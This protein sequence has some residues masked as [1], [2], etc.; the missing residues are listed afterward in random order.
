[1]TAP[2]RA[3]RP[4][5]RASRGALALLVA[6]IAL[7]VAGA[8]AQKPPRPRAGI[9]P[10]DLA[11]VARATGDDLR[12]AD[13]DIALAGKRVRFLARVASLED[14][15]DGRSAGTFAAG[16]ARLVLRFPAPLDAAGRLDHAT[17]W[18]VI[19][20]LLGPVALPD[21]RAAIAV[22]ADALVKTPGLPS[23]ERP[24][25]VVARV[26]GR[27]TFSD[28]RLPDGES[29]QPLYR[30]R[31][32]V[33]GHSR[34]FTKPG[35]TAL[36]ATSDG[37]GRFLE[38]RANLLADDGRMLAVECR[39]RI[40]DGALRNFEVSSAEISPAGEQSNPSSVD[41]EDDRWHDKWSARQKPFPPNTYAAN[42]LLPAMSGFPVGDA[43]VVR[44]HVWGDNSIPVPLYAYLDGEETV[45]VRGR[46]EAA[47]RVR[48]GLDA[49]EAARTIDLP[50]TFR[51][52]AEGASEVWFA[53]ESTWWIARD[54][55]H[56]VLRYRGPLGAPGSPEVETVRVR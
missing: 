41:F 25:D 55:P 10:L 21:G 18:E 53:D 49:R 16:G 51:D 23:Q 52:L 50:D 54:A 2:G 26:T 29:E 36:A 42:C 32:L 30:T 24:D 27:S 44:F 13:P 39:Y 37:R 12:L 20:R 47:L 3:A 4:R 33:P 31:V 6:L 7:P 46:P 48:V 28:P 38:Y 8:T 9:V 56:V 43:R 1:M 14:L 45:D 34:G 22:S 40:V 11:A 5:G 15:P 35:A 19:A 17:E